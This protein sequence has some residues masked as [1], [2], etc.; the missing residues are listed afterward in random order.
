MS[1]TMPVIQTI[2]KQLAGS[3]VQRSTRGTAI[4]IIRDDT[5]GGKPITQYA[6]T[7]AAQRDT[8]LYTAANLA[9][10]CDVLAF[11][12]AKTYVVR[13]STTAA[14][15][16]ALSLISR[17]IKNGWI[18]VCGTTK[19]TADLTALESWIKTQEAAQKGYK[20]FVYKST[21]PDCMHVVNFA[22]EKVT[23]GD[24]RAEQAGSFYLPSLIGIA[25]VCNIT[26]GMTNYLCKNLTRVEEVSDSDT[27]VGAG[28]FVL[29]NDDDGTVRVG[30]DV[31]SLTT[32]DGSAKTEDMK[33]IETV[34]AM[35][36]IREDVNSAY[37]Q[38]Y[39]GTYKNTLDNQMLFISAVSGYYK[40]LA[41]T[42]VLDAQ[43][44]NTAYIDVESQRAAWV[45]AGKAEAATWDDAT[46]R[47]MAFKKQLFLASDVKI[48]GSMGSMTMTVNLA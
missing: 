10:I 28:K 41:K 29:V 43:Y 25:A 2:F 14:I 35:D 26:R 5:E 37:K 47:A 8:A 6:D 46:V 19:L 13:I 15:A 4:L 48:V 44:E 38:T 39:Y 21:A 1:V 32:T 11:A 9:A 30:V 34:E 20:A 3:I 12:P 7:A 24:S 40:D 36:M 27:A 33:Y 17:N 16:D 31:N 18:T 23:F 45:A 42:D 22:N